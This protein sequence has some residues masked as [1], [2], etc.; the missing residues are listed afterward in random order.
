MARF[1]SQQTPEQAIESSIEE[2]ATTSKLRQEAP[3][4]TLLKNLTLK[5]KYATGNIYTSDQ[6]VLENLDET[7]TFM[8]TLALPHV[9]TYLVN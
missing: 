3:F 2:I 8:R 7:M 1:D 5:M 9:L 4:T 6:T